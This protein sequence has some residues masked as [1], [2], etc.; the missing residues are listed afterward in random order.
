MS[1]KLWKCHNMH[2][3]THELKGCHI[4]LNFSK[5]LSFTVKNEF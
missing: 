2:P 4:K 3:K 5:H 1:S